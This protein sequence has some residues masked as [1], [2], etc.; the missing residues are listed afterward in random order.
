MN[1]NAN[2]SQTAIQADNGAAVPVASEVQP[3][4]DG[5]VPAAP[6]PQ[7]NSLGML[8]PMLLLLAIF[9]FMMLRPQ[10][11]KEK[12]RRAMIEA[13]RAGARVVFG[14]G[15]VGTIVAATEK[16]FTVETAPGCSMTILRSSVQ[17]VAEEETKA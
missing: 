16:T 1:E 15:I 4:A 14:G 9:Y 2:Q 3:V 7:Q 5:S 8:V 11:R 10:Q 6:A 13:L 12:E 17:G